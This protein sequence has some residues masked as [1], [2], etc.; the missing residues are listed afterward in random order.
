MLLM[1]LLI[2]TDAWSAEV[3]RTI[4]KNFVVTS[5]TTLEVRNTFGAIHINN[6]DK[7]EFAVE[8]EIIGKSSSESR[9]QQI[10]DRI[11]I[12]I[13]E[14]GDRVSFE[15]ELNDIKTRGRDGF[16]VRY[17]ISMPADNPIRIR[18]SFG[19]VY[20]DDRNGSADLDISYGSLKAGDL[21]EESKVKLSF[22]KGYIDRFET[23]QLEV[24]YSELEISS[25]RRLDMDQQFSKVE[26]DEVDEL[27][28]DSKYG[29]VEIGAVKELDADVS[30]SGFTIEELITS[31]DLDAQYVSGFEIDMVR[32]DFEFL[33]IEG[34]FGSYDIRLEEGLQADIEA[35]FKYSD[36]KTMGA[37]VNFHYR[38]KDNNE[39]EYRGKI[40][41]GHPD[42]RIVIRSTYGNCTIFD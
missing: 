13:R 3:S 23:G 14:S 32:K 6:W 33:Y 26:I 5:S 42:R 1:L 35:E 36:L 24:K 22:G 40:G 19:D 11:E 7:G 18:N 9:A 15:T 37:D 28:L 30:Y 21:N 31:M 25:S 4:T 12:D 2:A 8:V 17:T 10:A 34:K 39:S 38:V 41:G 27:E 16:E 20:L 29:E